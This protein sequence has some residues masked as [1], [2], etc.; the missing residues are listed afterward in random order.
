ME[1]AC[2]NYKNARIAYSDMGQ[3]NVMVLLH[4]FLESSEIWNKFAS[5]LLK[6]QCR[7]IAID[8]PGHGQS[9]N[10]GYIHKMELMADCVKKVIDHLDIS[11]FILIGHSM[12]GYVSLAFAEK[13]KSLLKGLILFH[14]S[15]KADDK[16]KKQSR[17]KAIEVAKQN[18]SMYVNA[19]IPGLFKAENL[20]K[21]KTELEEIKSLAHQT[22]Q[23]GI[24]AALEG[25]RRRK[26]RQ[27][28]LR[29]FNQPVLFIIGKH[30]QAIP[31]QKVLP[32]LT[33]SYHTEALILEGAAHMGF[34]EA[35]EETLSAV[36]AFTTKIFETQQ[37]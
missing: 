18:Q 6:H 3:G 37:Q 25:M 26:G 32:Q 7:V 15:A 14:S 20:E 8:L 23:Q 10:I 30:D 2:I 21:Y 4:G 9:E 31:L 16:Q 28:I 27:M 19:T 5:Q 36:K 33:L 22:S 13:H 11:D 34:I 12:G 24:V 17:L 1:K 29:S 35:F